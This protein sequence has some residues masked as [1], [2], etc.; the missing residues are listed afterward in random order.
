MLG[1]FSIARCLLP[2]SCL[3]LLFVSFGSALGQGGGNPLAGVSMELLRTEFTTTRAKS[4]ALFNG[5]AA[6]DT[7]DAAQV[8]A[9]D[10]AARWTLYRFYDRAGKEVNFVDTVFQEFEDS[11]LGL[12]LKNKEKNQGVPQLFTKQIIKHAK[13]VLQ[14]QLPWP[15]SVPQDVNRV[16]LARLNAA[17]VLER[18]TKLGQTELADALLEILD[19]ELQND[20][21]VQAAVKTGDWKAGDIMPQRNDG[22]KLYVLRG[23]GE[24]LALPG[25]NP[26]VVTKDQEK[27]IILALAQFVERP[28]T[29]DKNSA[30]EEIEG[31]RML[32]REA[33]RALA[34]GQSPSIAGNDKTRPALVLLRVVANDGLAP[35]PRMDERVEAA[36]GVLRLSP[37]LDKTYQQEYAVYQV[38]LFMEVFGEFVINHKNEMKP[39]KVYAAKLVDALEPLRMSKNAAVAK[40]AEHC[41]NLVSKVELEGNLNNNLLTNYD[42]WIE[43]NPVNK[44]T[45]FAGVKD[46]TV[47]P[48]NRPAGD[49]PEKQ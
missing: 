23:L 2:V 28:P 14:L 20:A 31:A 45:L 6:L 17:R 40:I 13:L 7:T 49:A 34:Y 19:Q 38:G 9:L 33:I 8:S 44:D 35:E 11:Q 18:M 46:S 3:A 36:V 15:L 26:P 22:V 4:T 43:G 47:K 5:N 29:V 27:K 10:C 16:N 42:T 24:M 41:I 32:R 37:E 12:I 48:A 21:K 25:Q 1:R 30:A 39:V